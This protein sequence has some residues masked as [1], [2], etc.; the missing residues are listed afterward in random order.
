MLTEIKSISIIYLA[1]LSVICELLMLYS[2]VRIRQLKK[3]PETLIFWG[4]CAQLMLELHW[5]TA[6]P[7]I[8]T[9]LKDYQCQ[10]LGAISIY[11]YFLTWNYTLL[12]SVEIL[13]KILYPH[14]TNYKSRK[15]WYH[16]ISNLISFAVF[17][18][19]MSVENNGNSVSGT[20]FVQNKR[21]LEILVAF[22]VFF[23]FPLIVTFTAYSVW[24]SYNTVY[25]KYLNCHMLVVVMFSLCYMPSA[26]AH[27]LTVFNV[28][29]VPEWYVAVRNT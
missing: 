13:I 25:S 27:L 23:Q 26:I 18:F 21:D 3:H 22:P 6:L 9:H 4:S 14:Q 11:F 28:E 10:F 1:S 7:S 12:L 16:S 24:I 20:C 17:I 2:Y 5:F 29:S 19:L 8:K 15:I